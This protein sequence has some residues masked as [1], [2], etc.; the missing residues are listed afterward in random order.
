[1]ARKKLTLKTHPL[2]PFSFPYRGRTWKV[3]H[4]NKLT[5]EDCHGTCDFAEGII[6][7]SKETWLGDEYTLRVTIWHEIFHVINSSVLGGLDSEETV[8][9]KVLHLD[10]MLAESGGQG[11]AEIAIHLP[12]W[13]FSVQNNEKQNESTN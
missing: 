11:F 3:V 6:E 8:S 4:V 13:L 2:Q 12:S 7:I 1:M 5:L 9:M 10:E